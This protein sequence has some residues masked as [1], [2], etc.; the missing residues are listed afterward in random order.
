VKF[1]FILCPTSGYNS[2]YCTWYIGSKQSTLWKQL[3][4][5]DLCMPTGKPLEQMK[6]KGDVCHKAHLLF[7]DVVFAFLTTV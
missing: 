2:L 5:E 4:E 1:L 3:E 7:L 6:P